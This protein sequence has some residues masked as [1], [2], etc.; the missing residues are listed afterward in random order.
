MEVSQYYQHQS[1]CNKCCRVI[2]TPMISIESGRRRMDYCSMRCY[3]TCS[4]KNKTKERTL[5]TGSNN[6]NTNINIINDHATNNNGSNN[7]GINKST[8][9][10]MCLV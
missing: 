10:N 6:S 7:S 3:S 2:R 4:N 9:P 1:F 8:Y 5:S